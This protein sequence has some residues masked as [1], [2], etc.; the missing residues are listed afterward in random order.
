MA[1]YSPLFKPGAAITYSVSADVTAGQVV[2]LTG[3][4]AVGPASADSE[5]VVGIAAFNAVVGDHVTV[6]DGGVQRP[7]ASGVI[8]AGDKVAAAADGKVVT[9]GEAV[10]TIGIALAAAADGDPVQLK[11]KA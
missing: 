6:H 3:D 7:Y 2:E 1:D 5:K 8:A 11:F 10:N 9:A 4:R